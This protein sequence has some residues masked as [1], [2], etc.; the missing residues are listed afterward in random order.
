MSTVLRTPPPP[1]RRPSAPGGP[2]AVAAPLGSVATPP[3]DGPATTP[4]VPFAALSLGVLVAVS[5]GV[6][7][8]RNGAGDTAEVS[9]PAV[10]GWVIGGVLCLVTFAC[11]RSVD[12]GRQAD[13]QYVEPAWRPRRWASVLT[14]IGWLASIGC[15]L[16]V[17]SSVARR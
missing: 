6:Y 8:W 1:P 5:L 11:F 14:V 12:L 16:L 9:L 15:A 10:V 4:L 13:P 7:A 2:A 3:G 17:A